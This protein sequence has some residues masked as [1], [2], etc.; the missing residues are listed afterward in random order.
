ME[1]QRIVLI[2]DREN[3]NEYESP[4]SEN[5]KLVTFL[6]SRQLLVSAEVWDDDKVDWSQYDVIIL[7]SP[8]DYIV[9]VDAFYAWLDR[10]SQLNILVLNPIKTIM[11]NSNK[12]YLRDLEDKGVSVIPSIWLDKKSSFKAEEIFERFGGEKII[13]KPCISGS[14]RHTY[15]LTK[16]DAKSKA[17]EIEQLLE[18]EAF[19]VQPFIKEIQTKG[20]WSLLFFNGRYSHAVLKTAKSGDFRVQSDYG[21]ES[22]KE[23]PY[24]E[25][26]AS[27]QSIVDC[28][29]K[30]CLY[31]RVDGIEINKQLV[32]MELELIEPELFLMKGD[33]AFD[34]YY[35]AI[36]PL[37][38]QSLIKTA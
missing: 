24:P 29:A 22:R 35:K 11:W 5:G 4:G 10:L 19:M 30:G 37:L 6:K 20:E 3:I 21:G 36:L 26:V 12:I 2:G 15:A 23:I 1:Q 7:K 28:F 38:E 34:N 13:V 9:K 18:C 8:W 32:L 31:A 16:E 25:L 14:A 17:A 27:A 33:E